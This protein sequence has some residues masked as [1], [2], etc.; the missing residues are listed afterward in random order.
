LLLHCWHGHKIREKP[1]TG[2]NLMRVAGG[3]GMV[4]FGA[5]YPALLPRAASGVLRQAPSASW[6]G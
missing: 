5:L 4:V 3:H 2:K 1:D 6:S